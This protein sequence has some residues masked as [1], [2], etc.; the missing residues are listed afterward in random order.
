MFSVFR[1]KAAQKHELYDPSLGVSRLSK[2]TV[3]AVR[4]IWMH[5]LIPVTSLTRIYVKLSELQMT[6]NF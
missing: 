4:N 3:Q 1:I 2:V 6:F 5:R